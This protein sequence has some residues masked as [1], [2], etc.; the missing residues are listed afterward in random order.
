MVGP[1]FQRPL[2]G[3]RKRVDGD[4]QAGSG[5]AGDLYRMHTKTTYAPETDKVPDAKST[6]IDQSGEWR[7]YRV[8][9]ECCL[10]DRHVIGNFR[11]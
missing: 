1:K 7:R 9:N 8:S 4:D 3:S 6:T 5:E 10:F 11:Q 2:A